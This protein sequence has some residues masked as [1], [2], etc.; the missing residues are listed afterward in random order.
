MLLNAT[1]IKIGLWIFRCPNKLFLR[2][3]ALQCRTM[4][5]NKALSRVSL[6]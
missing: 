2:V 3:T 6:S 1:G 5:K 4:I